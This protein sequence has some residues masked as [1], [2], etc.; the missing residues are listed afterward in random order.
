MEESIDPRNG[1]AA[2]LQMTRNMVD[3]ILNRF[4]I[5]RR[6]AEDVSPLSLA[7]VG[8][9]VYEL[10]LRT[11]LIERAEGSAKTHTREGSRLAKAPTQAAMM[12]AILPDLDPDEEAAYRRGRNASPGHT[13][14]SATV[15]EYRVATGFEALVGWLY[16]QEKTERI[17]ELIKLGWDR[18]G[19][20]QK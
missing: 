1:D 8:D 16:L 20:W 14:R 5:A 4:E 18:T 15:A 2:S 3:E 6:R 13:A 9:C 7:Y 10:I 12:H 11:C 19:V 17:Y